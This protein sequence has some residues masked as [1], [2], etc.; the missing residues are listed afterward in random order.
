MDLWLA[1]ELKLCS[2]YTEIYV[3]LPSKVSNLKKQFQILL[4]KNIHLL[5]T[6]FFFKINKIYNDDIFIQSHLKIVPF[7]LLPHNN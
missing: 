6:Y 3:A 4:C 1:L 2:N 5:L 7:N